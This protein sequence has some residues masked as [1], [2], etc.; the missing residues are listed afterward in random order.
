MQ[1]VRSGQPI[2]VAAVPTARQQIARRLEAARV[3]ACRPSLVALA[4]QTGMGYRH[5]VAVA[6]GREPLTATD[7]RDLAAALDVPPSGLRD[8]WS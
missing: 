4:R 7:Q 5:L 6:N 3:L 2:P 8:G 1:T